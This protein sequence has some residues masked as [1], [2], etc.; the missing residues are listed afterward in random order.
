VKN[1][2]A[3]REASSIPEEEDFY[4]RLLTPKHRDYDC[5]QHYWSKRICEPSG[6]PQTL[7]LTPAQFLVF[8]S[9]G[10]TPCGLLFLPHLDG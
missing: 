2:A 4:S 1:L 6:N 5:I 8:Y 7:G 3:S 10:V 9:F